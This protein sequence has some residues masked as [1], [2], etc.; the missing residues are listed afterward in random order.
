MSTINSRDGPSLTGCSK[1][2]RTAHIQSGYTTELAFI[3][4]TRLLQ[5]LG[6]N[7]YGGVDGVRNNGEN[8]V[9]AEF[10]T[11]LHE[12]FNDRCVCVEKVVASHAGLAWYS[13]RNDDHVCAG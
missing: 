13:G 3:I 1:C 8:R 7:G 9:W 5:N 4:N 6:S 2:I 12:S 11:S 10:G